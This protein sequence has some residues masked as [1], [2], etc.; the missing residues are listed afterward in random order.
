MVY[1]FS[2]LQAD[3]LALLKSIEAFANVDPFFEDGLFTNRRING[4]GRRRSPLLD[5]ILMRPRIAN[6]LAERAPRSLL[7]RIRQLVDA[8]SAPASGDRGDHQSVRTPEY[9]RLAERHFSE[10]QRAIDD[11]FKRGQV[12]TGPDLMPASFGPP[13][14]IEGV[15]RSIE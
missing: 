6:L 8:R 11:L 14:I 3:P 5:R 13:G 2:L 4:L 12:L 10:D 15:S 1:D 7:L 9:Q